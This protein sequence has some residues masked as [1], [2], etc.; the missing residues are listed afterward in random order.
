MKQNHRTEAAGASASRSGALST[1]LGSQPASPSRAS[2]ATPRLRW[3]DCVDPDAS[4]Q[5][6]RH[7]FFAAIG[8]VS[9]L[10]KSAAKVAAARRNGRLGGRPRKAPR[11]APATQPT[12]ATIH[13]P[14]N[15]AS[16]EASKTVPLLPGQEGAQV[17]P[18]VPLDVC[19]QASR[20][21][22][23]LSGKQAGKAS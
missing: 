9:G 4:R 3:V 18:S 14:R 13:D 5:E 7:Q 11:L 16:Q 22:T 15:A 6:Q 1:T 10:S 20:I 12:S 8:H 23:G 2:E 17:L 21:S 19:K